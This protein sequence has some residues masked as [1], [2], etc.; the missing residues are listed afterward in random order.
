MPITI[1]SCFF[2]FKYKIFLIFNNTIGSKKP[3][4]NA[5]RLKEKLI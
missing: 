1:L 4:K 2:V 3:E 5:A